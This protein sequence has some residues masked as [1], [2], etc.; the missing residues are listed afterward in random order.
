LK[1]FSVKIKKRIAVIGSGSWATAI[2]KILTDNNFNVSWYIRNSEQ[3]NYIKKNS[4]NPKYLRSVKLKKLK[5]YTEI[6]DIVNDNEILVFA[7][8]SV[9]F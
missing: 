5:L 6:N 4:Y 3:K 2:I 8:P 9:Y 7:I 1:T